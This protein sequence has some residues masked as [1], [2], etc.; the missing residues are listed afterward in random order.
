LGITA[1]DIVALKRT[2]EIDASPIGFPGEVVKITYR[3]NYF[4]ED[5]ERTQRAYLESK[6]IVE[7]IYSLFLSAVTEWDIQ[8]T[9]E[10]PALVPLTMEGLKEARISSKVIYYFWSRIL[11]DYRL[12]ESSAVGGSNGSQP[13]A[14]S[15]TSPQTGPGSESP[16][17]STTARS[18]SS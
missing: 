9:K 1:V 12:G 6:S 2:L 14:S 8:K 5:A 16:T 17:T 3:P 10:S 7:P 4:D 18:G 11:E 15:E 13:A